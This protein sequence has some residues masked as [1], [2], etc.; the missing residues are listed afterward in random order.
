MNSP[1]SIRARLLNVSKQ[2]G[3]DFQAILTHYAIERFLYRLGASGQRDTFILKGAMLFVAWRGNLHRPTKDLDLLGFGS[4]S[5]EDVAHRIREIA[6]TAG[7]D[8]IVFD[9]DSVVTEIIRKTPSTKGSGP[10]LSQPWTRLG[11]ECKST[12]VS[13]MQCS[14]SRER[15]YSRPS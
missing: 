7:D 4:P 6:R 10:S 3:E 5:V 14:Q 13:A 8:G 9:P 1:A 11:F 15:V 12:S 2:S